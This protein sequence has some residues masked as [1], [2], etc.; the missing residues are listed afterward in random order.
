M[1]NFTTRQGVLFYCYAIDEK[2]KAKIDQFLSVLENSG[3]SSIIESAV[4]EQGLGRPGFNPYA[5]F[6]ATLYGFAMG[7]AT[8]RE[9]E[10]S[11]RNDIRFRYIMNEE[12]PTY[13]SFSNFINKVITPHADEVFACIV[14]AYLHRCNL[15]V[16]DCHIDGTKFE[17]KSNKYKV[18]WKPT[19]F[20]LNLSSKIRGLLKELD[21]LRGIPTE[22]IIDSHLIAKK[23]DEASELL[24][25][26]EA[27]TIKMRK[28]QITNLSEYLT[29]SLE[30]EEKERICG[31]YRNSYYKTD[32]DATAMCLKEDYYS[33]L[34]S[35]LHAAY[36]MQAVVSHGFV[37]AYY[38][39]QDRT[40]IHT[41]IPTLEHFRR[42]HGRLPV[43]ITADAGYGCW[44][45][46]QFCKTNS[47][48]AYIKYQA[49]EGECSARRPA[50][51][52]LNADN[53]ITC[54]GGRKGIETEI[55]GRHHK[56]KNAKFFCVSCDETCPFMPYCRQTMKEDVGTERIFEINLEYQQLKQE[57]RDRLLSVKGIEMRVNRSCQVE[58][59]YG[60]AKYNMQYSRIRRVGLTRVKTEYMLTMLGLNTRKLLRYLDGKTNFDYWKPPEGLVAEK[61]KKPSAKR[62]A[63]RAQKKRQKQP[64]EI[65][66]D[67]YKYAAQKY[68]GC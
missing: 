12:V 51:F 27:S 23:L 35:N 61:F 28:A 62:L 33:G 52:E 29:K 59:V 30:Y 68:R 8:L 60:I 66:R 4:D 54:L 10:S 47:I 41:F 46:Y 31:P 42:V 65:A 55:P 43:R 24:A 45:N 48:E 17:A 20:H 26:A 22:G 57:A 38:V 49:W 39:S 11:C 34:G 36:Q 14:K 50:L 67:S 5:M 40:D 9:L 25:F 63:N 16:E 21:L 6:A 58:G 15:G 7:S 18:V 32:H 37:V 44:E 53:S 1:P 2:Q 19:R 3:I 56:L 13:A 64:N